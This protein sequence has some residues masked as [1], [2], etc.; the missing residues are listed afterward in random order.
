MFENLDSYQRCV[1]VLLIV[2]AFITLVNFIVTCLSADNK[3]CNKKCPKPDHIRRMPKYYV[4]SKVMIRDYVFD[5]HSLGYVELKSHQGK[6]FKVVDIYNTVDRGISYKIRR[7]EYRETHFGDCVLYAV[8]EFVVP[9]HYLKWS[10]DS[11]ILFYADGDV[12]NA[13]F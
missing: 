8:H 6:E 1:I 9:E 12:I 5:E 4:E 2:T 3:E 13:R 11:S 10:T 7:E